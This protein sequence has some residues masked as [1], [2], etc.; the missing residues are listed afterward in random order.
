MKPCTQAEVDFYQGTRIAHPDFAEFMPTYMG[1]L[2]LGPPAVPANVGH[3]D[4]LLE[5]DPAA[6]LPKSQGKKIAAETAIVL[7]NLEHGFYR[8]NAIDIKLGSRLYA[9]G[10][11]ASTLR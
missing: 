4:A 1:T 10:T 3:L 7:E 6:D 11:S 2:T 9:P 5:A 8:P